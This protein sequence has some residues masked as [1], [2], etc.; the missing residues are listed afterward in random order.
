MNRDVNENMHTLVGGKSGNGD[1]EIF[2]FSGKKK[3]FIVSYMY[4]LVPSAIVI[5]F[6]KWDSL[7]LIIIIM[8]LLTF[9]LTIWFYIQTAEVIKIN[10]D[11][12][13]IRKFG[14]SE[15]IPWK[16]LS[17]FSVKEMS[18]I[19]FT[20]FNI[21]WKSG[22]QNICLKKFFVLNSVLLIDNKKQIDNLVS[23]LTKYI[24]SSE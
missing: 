18:G 7:T 6:S 17:S 20:R 23:R 13:F 9:L 14:S 2:V 21:N 12:L 3:A 5:F 15:K 24:N 22:V 11:G 10:S 19:G 16:S 8:A 1:D 4:V